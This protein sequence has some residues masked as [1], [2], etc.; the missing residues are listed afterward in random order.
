M[1]IKRTNELS[2]KKKFLDLLSNVDKT[3]RLLM[4]PDT[5]FPFLTRVGM[6][7]R[8]F[9]CRSDNSQRLM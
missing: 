3:L 5:Q 2:D 1:P 7:T 9:H 8:L 6:S 4:V